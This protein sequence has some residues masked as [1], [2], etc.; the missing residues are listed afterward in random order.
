MSRRPGRIYEIVDVAQLRNQENWSQYERI[1]DVMD[2]PSFVQIRTHIW[3]LL[4]DKV[5][6]KV[7]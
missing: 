6:L 7:E 3:R 5:N 1:E 4:R 2:Q